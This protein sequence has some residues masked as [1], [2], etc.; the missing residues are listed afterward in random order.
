MHSS[1]TFFKSGTAEAI[2]TDH[3]ILTQDVCHISLFKLTI[4]IIVNKIFYS[5]NVGNSLL[6]Y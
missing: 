6:F 4:A 1:P 2:S 3:K 5:Y